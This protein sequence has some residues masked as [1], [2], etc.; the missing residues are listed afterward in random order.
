MMLTLLRA[1]SEEVDMIRT[2]MTVFERGAAADVLLR[3]KTRALTI[4]FK[5]LSLAHKEGIKD[6]TLLATSCMSSWILCCASSR[7]HIVNISICL[8]LPYLDNGSLV[9]P[10]LFCLQ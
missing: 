2:P 5:A 3:I 8:F 6:I 10:I 1:M 4:I 7:Y 9:V